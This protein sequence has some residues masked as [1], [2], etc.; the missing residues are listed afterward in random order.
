MKNEKT[1]LV[2]VD[3]IKAFVEPKTAEGDC[4]LYMP[5]A[6][7]LIPNI[8][9]IIEGLGPEDIIVHVNDSHKKK[10]EEFIKFPAHAIKGT[11]QSQV[12][13]GFIYSNKKPRSIV[14]TR[15]SGFFRTDL[16]RY[17]YSQGVKKIIIVG[18][19]TEVCILH[20][21]MDANMRNY[22]ITVKE[23]SITGITQEAHMAIISYMQN[24]LR[25]KVE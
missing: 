24:I 21:V 20:T 13:E 16:Q 8:N 17:L 15:F 9:K 3:M 5:K 23:N 4:A 22:D 14:K 7:E 25:V 11:E 18:V 10:D 12:A 2:I 1:A 19:A 6:K